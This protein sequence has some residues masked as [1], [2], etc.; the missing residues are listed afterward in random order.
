MFWSL[1]ERLCYVQDHPG[2]VVQGPGP[3]SS[4]DARLWAL[5]DCWYTIVVTAGALVHDFGASAS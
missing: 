1:Q 4:A 5:W 3:F 2:S